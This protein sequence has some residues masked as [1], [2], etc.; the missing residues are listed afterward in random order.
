MPD[1]DDQKTTSPE[2][3]SSGT[4]PA[5]ES[6][7]EAVRLASY[8]TVFLS[9]TRPF[10]EPGLEEDDWPEDLDGP[11]T[12]QMLTHLG[13]IAA[14]AS[15]CIH[16]IRCQNKIADEAKPELD[17]IDKLLDEAWG[18]LRALTETQ[19]PETQAPTAAQ[20][21]ALDF[22]AA[23]AAIPSD[24]PTRKATPGTVAPHTARPPK[25]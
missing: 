5:L 1:P 18:R 25:P 3:G 19:G 13:D 21:A 12:L 8:A 24:A 15:D 4:H 20:H 7:S 6:M 22:P 9:P 16:G 23:P 14:H 2:T 10:D 17:K 11:E